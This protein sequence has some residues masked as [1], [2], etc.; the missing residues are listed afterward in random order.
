MNETIGFVGL[1]SM[2]VAMALRLAER[3]FPLRVWNRSPEKAEPLVRQ[4]QARAE[5]PEETAATGGIVVSMLA[6][7]RAV[8]KLFGAN[9]PLLSRLGTGGLHISMSTIHPE[10]SRRLA[11]EHRAA[12][13]GYVTAPVFGRPDSAAAGTLWIPVSGSESA[14]G[15]ARP[16]L[17]ALSRGIFEFGDDPGSANTVKLCGNFLIAAMME[18]Q[19]EVAAW[20]ERSGLGAEAVMGMLSQTLFPCPVFQNYGKRIVA[21]EFQPAGFRL[22]LGLK[23]VELAVAA[24]RAVS[25]PLPLGSLVRDRALAAVNSGHANWDWSSLTLESRVG[26]GLPQKS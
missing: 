1:G 12:G 17:E 25:V 21:R 22:T 4:G 26:A 10:T 5:R 13:V 19:G 23:D 16:L 14:R 20:A 8:T 3:G 9:S 11:A 7:D 6:D 15:R 24:A 18:A 2:G